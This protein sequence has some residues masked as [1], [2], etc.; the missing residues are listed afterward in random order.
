MYAQ[1]KEPLSAK[2]GKLT[3]YYGGHEQELDITEAM[4]SGF[5]NTKLGKQTLTVHYLGATAA[6]TVTVKA[7][8]YTH[9]V[10][11]W[12]TTAIPVRWRAAWPPS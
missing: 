6:F 3:A 4:V 7:V 10:N 8:S 1:G 5:D 12:L 2:G 9:L 11:G